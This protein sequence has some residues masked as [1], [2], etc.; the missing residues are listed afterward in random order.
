MASKGVAVGRIA[1]EGPLGLDGAA[2]WITAAP[3]EIEDHLLTYTS[4]YTGRWFE[5]FAYRSR[6]D[7]FTAEDV[8]AVTA[9]SVKIPIGS[10]QRLVEDENGELSRLLAQAQ[11]LATAPGAAAGLQEL[12]LDGE[13]ARTLSD[14]YALVKEMSGVGKVSKSKLL[15]AKFPSHVPI[16]DAR[17][18]QLLG[19]ESSYEWWAPMQRLLTSDGVLT[20]LESVELSVDRPEVSVLRRLDIVLW[21]EAERRGLG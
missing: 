2:A 8:L 15:A 14:L 18:E 17:V 5:W 21:R 6:P 20:V 13:L 1:T 7:C 4:T 9:L 10:A 16:R 3:D 12:D 11:A 19:L